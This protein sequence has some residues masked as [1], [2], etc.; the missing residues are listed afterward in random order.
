MNLFKLNTPEFLISKR[1]NKI[2]AKK[3]IE[4]FFATFK[5]KMYLRVSLDE[6]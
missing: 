2:A 3:N 4:F 5:I 1:L 6:F